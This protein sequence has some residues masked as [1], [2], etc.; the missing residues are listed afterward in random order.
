MASRITGHP[1]AAFCPTTM[2][3][4]APCGIL[5]HIHDRPITNRTDEEC[6]PFIV[7]MRKSRFTH[8]LH[9]AS[10]R[11]LKKNSRLLGLIPSKEKRFLGFLWQGVFFV[12][13]KEQRENRCP[14]KP[15]WR[16]SELLSFLTQKER[17]LNLLM[18]A[19]LALMQRL[20]YPFFYFFY[21]SSRPCASSRGLPVR[22]LYASNPDHKSRMNRATGRAHPPEKTPKKKQKN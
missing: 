14:F 19:I 13:K 15:L 18:G 3:Q 1:S 6:K 11:M 5:P 7:N 9:I 20:V 12:K 2:R 10:V 4:I 16:P 8:C 22:S 17:N 21:C